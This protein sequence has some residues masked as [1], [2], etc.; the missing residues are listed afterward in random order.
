MHNRRCSG[1]LTGF[2]AMISLGPNWARPNKL[3]PEPH[4]ICQR[5]AAFFA[6]AAYIRSEHEDGRRVTVRF[7]SQI[8][9]K[10]I[11]GMDMEVDDGSGTRGKEKLP[12]RVSRRFPYTFRSFYDSRCSKVLRSDAFGIFF[13]LVFVVVGSEVEEKGKRLVVVLVGAPGSGKSTFCDAVIGAS[14]RTWVRVCQVSLSLSLSSTQ[15]ICLMKCFT[16]L[17]LY[18]SCGRLG[19]PVF[20]CLWCFSLSTFVLVPF[21][22]SW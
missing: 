11:L 12:G 6:I 8:L 22:Q 18:F 19:F 5:E 20:V 13:V 9:L 4:S 15:P 3:P 16:G 1:P 2:K 14:R 10:W 21:L 17:A 7:S